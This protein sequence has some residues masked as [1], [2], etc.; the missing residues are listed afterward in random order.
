MVIPASKKFASN[1]G[2]K[3]PDGRWSEFET[4]VL[5]E[6]ALQNSNQDVAQMLCL[7]NDLVYYSKAPFCIFSLLK[8]VLFREKTYNQMY[9]KLNNMR[10]H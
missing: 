5:N 4:I 9:A 3:V 6:I 1:R 7:Y 8:T 2:E 10:K